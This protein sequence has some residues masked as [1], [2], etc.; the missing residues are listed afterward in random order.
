M[1]LRLIQ[2]SFAHSL[3]QITSA[4]NIPLHYLALPFRTRFD[5]TE[6]GKGDLA[7]G[8]LMPHCMCS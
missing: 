3:L 1:S 7:P 8:D 2:R 4:D 5:P 6:I